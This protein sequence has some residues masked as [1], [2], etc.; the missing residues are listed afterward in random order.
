MG[1]VK[2]GPAVTGHPTFGRLPADVGTA[3]VF[4]HAVHTLV[5]AVDA[6][7]LVVAEEKATVA[8][9]LVAAH[10]VDTDLLA[11]A[12]VVL[13]LVHIQAVVSIMGQHEAVKAG[14]PVV[15]WD[16]DALVHAAP[17][18]VVILTLVDVCKTRAGR[19]FRER[20]GGS[21]LPAITEATRV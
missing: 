20:A 4:V 16:V 19:A 7:M 17:V 10:G 9:T 14:A 3:V 2:A 21:P 5:G 11:A 1:K 15:P 8:L 13:T 12:V 6:G 18:V